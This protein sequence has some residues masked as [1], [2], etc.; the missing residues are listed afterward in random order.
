MLRNKRYHLAMLDLHMPKMD[1]YELSEIVSKNYPDVHI[2]IFTAD[3]MDDVRI[4]L[5][6]MN[7]FDI[8]HKPLLPAEL[9]QTL[10]R[11]VQLRAIRLGVE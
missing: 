8:L 6:E 4:R 2:V 1:G 9:L 10:Q 5:A 11:V 3:I 7:I